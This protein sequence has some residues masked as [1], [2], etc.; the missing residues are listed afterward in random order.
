MKMKK[1]HFAAAAGLFALALSACT[2]ENVAVFTEFT[3]K[4]SDRLEQFNPAT[5]YLN[6]ILSGCY[7]DP[8]ITRKGED[9]YLANS[10]FSYYPGLP[11]WHSRDLVNWE[12]VGY[13]LDRPSQLNLGDGVGLSEGIFAPDI[14]YN[15]Y[16][17]TFY[18]IVTVVG[19]GGNIVVKTKDPAK[20]WSD[21]IPVDVPGIDPS[22]YFS[23]D[24][25]AYIVNNQE[26]DT[27]AEYDGHRAI[28]LREYDLATDKVVG[29]CTQIV[30]KGVRPEDK[31]IWIEGPH[32]YH[33][34]GTYYLMCAEGG[35]GDG[36][37]EVVFRSDSV[38]GP[39][40]PCEINP[41]LTQRTLPKNRLAPVTAAGH[42][43]LIQ[44]PE[45]EWWAVFLS[46][47]PYRY[48]EANTLCNT[49]R[50]TLLLPV[51]WENGQPVIL[52]EGQTV[53][54]VV[55][56]SGIAADGERRNNTGNV[57]FTD[58]F[59][60]AKLDPF[61]LQVRTPQSEWYRLT[62]KGLVLQPRDVSIYEEKNPSFLCRWIKNFNFTATLTMDYQPQAEGDLAG[63]V[64][65]QKE[66]Y[67]YVIGKTLD[68]DGRETIVLNKCAGK[69]PE[70]VASADAEEYAG[71]PV[72]FKI[73]AIGRDYSFYYSFDGTDWKQLGRV[74]DGAILSTQVA[75]GFT[76]AVVGMYATT[77][78]D[79]MPVAAE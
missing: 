16:N 2:Q 73:E 53:P 65:Y 47:L 27:P 23:P 15:P 5:Q 35:T 51:R 62:D 33:I 6:P 8:S 56:K 69:G 60:G 1:T 59:K 21:P 50:N 54:Y 58:D 77:A 41:I 70:L 25:K 63:F 22:F 14:K 10:S 13:A 74:Q 29:T 11:V 52:D 24:G 12:L 39:Y 49:G 42:A 44:T 43:D 79:R 7:P 38:R 46:I 48:D 17:D 26:P 72:R 71:E 67:N 18:L 76:G 30:N 78:K 75:G 19:G 32:L 4:G 20:G 40:V 66:N 55:D 68:A 9:Y 34:D 3:Y 61:W 57:E 64:C 36:H 37:S 31:P 28:G 45:G